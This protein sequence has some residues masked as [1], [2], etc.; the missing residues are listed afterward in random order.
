[1]HAVHGHGIFSES[2]CSLVDSIIEANSL[3]THFL[4]LKMKLNARH[5]T[6]NTTPAVARMEKMM[7]SD[8]ATVTSFSNGTPSCGIRPP[9]M[10]G[11]ELVLL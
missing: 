4:F 1:M 8:R 11:M 5:T 10:L 3:T 7:V 2:C 9:G 6:A